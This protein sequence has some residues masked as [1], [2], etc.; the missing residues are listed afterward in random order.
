[1]AQ[2]AEHTLHIHG[3]EAVLYQ[4]A[5]SPHWHLR[6]HLKNRKRAGTTTKKFQ[7]TLLNGL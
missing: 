2:K 1:M 6:Y 3:G 7:K 4:L 5:G